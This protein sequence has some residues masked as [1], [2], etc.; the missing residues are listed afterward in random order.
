MA[1][2]SPPSHSTVHRVASMTRDPGPAGPQEPHMALG[3]GGHMSNP[4]L[5]HGAQVPGDLG[6][7]ANLLALSSPSPSMGSREESQQGI[8]CICKLTDSLPA[9][10]PAS[11]LPLEG[12]TG[13]SREPLPGQSCPKGTTALR[14]SVTDQ[15]LQFPSHMKGLLLC[16]QCLVLPHRAAAQ[17]SERH[18]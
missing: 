10:R 3:R 12:S 4:S 13:M 6:I 5:C 2:P 9:P 16:T 7:S 11:G 15:Q 17:V 1:P 18:E 14:N 8:P